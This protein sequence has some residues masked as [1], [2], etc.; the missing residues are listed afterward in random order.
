MTDTRKLHKPLAPGDLAV[1]RIG[2]RLFCGECGVVTSL[3]SENDLCG[4]CSESLYPQLPQ[5]SFIDR[6]LDRMSRTIIGL[7]SYRDTGE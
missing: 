1:G 2:D 6:A 7:A 3:L 4:P 5:P